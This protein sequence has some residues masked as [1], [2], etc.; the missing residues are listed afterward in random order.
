M[1]A[2]DRHNTS[3]K[4]AI[5]S[6]EKN[7]AHVHG[8]C[9]SLSP[10]DYVRFNELT[11]PLE[12]TGKH[13]RPDLSDRKTSAFTVVELEGN[14]TEYHLLCWERASAGPLLYPRGEWT[15]NS[16]HSRVKWDYGSGERVTSL[17][18]L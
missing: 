6:P 16:T 1:T 10:G 12:V 3:G 17:E 18:I 14:Q 8:E 15:E 9:R 2:G 5:K 7:P 4:S 13:S 11:V